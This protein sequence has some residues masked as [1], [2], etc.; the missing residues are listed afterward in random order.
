MAI[1]GK[2]K[3]EANY[4]A[5]TTDSSTSLKDFSL[6]R[7][8]YYRKYIEGET[9]DEKENRAST[10]GKIVETLLME[11][12]EFDS[13]FYLSTCLSAPTGNMIEFVEALYRFTK[14]ATDETGKVI[15]TFEDL[16]RDA[17][18]ESGYKIPYERVMFGT[19]KTSGFVGSEAEIYYNE[20][21]TVR[22]KNLIV[23]TSQE[24]SNAEKIVEELRTNSVTKDI[25]NLVNSS[26]YTILN[27]YQVPEYFVDEHPLK[28]MLDKVVVD[29]QEKVIKPYDLKCTWSVEDFYEDY[30]LYRRAYI[31]G[32][33]YWRSMISLTEDPSSELYGYTVDYLRFIVCD[34]TNY[35]NPLIFEMTEESM[36]NAYSGFEH[37]GRTYPGVGEIIDG[38]KW[39]LE[40][41]IWNISKKNYENFGV[42]KLN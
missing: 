22:S 8:K 18:K 2:V 19:E 20:I 1:Q 21:R 11:P 26:R 35:M 42:V 24:I 38:L 13:R 23:V 27:Q 40:K 37:K 7:K 14:E 36:E 16:T 9:I 25:V 29:H 30:Y 33:V 32:F 5:I 28:S 34:S 39:A 6:D 15:R 12:E 41:N 31:Q 3:T 10:M 17:Y 4:R